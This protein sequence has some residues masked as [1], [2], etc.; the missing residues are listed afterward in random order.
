MALHD[1]IKSYRLEK[2][3]TQTELADLIGI[4]QPDL[5]KI[6]SGIIKPDIIKLM[7]FAKIFEIDLNDFTEHSLVNNTNNGEN[8]TNNNFVFNEKTKNQDKIATLENENLSLKSEIE[9]LRKINLAL[10]EKRK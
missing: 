10:I 5:S 2:K 8:Y 1:K 7:K 6:E 3:M 9:Y 4:E